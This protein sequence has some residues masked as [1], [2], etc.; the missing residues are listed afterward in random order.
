LRIRAP[1]FEHS[2]LQ[3][4]ERS[5]EISKNNDPHSSQDERNELAAH[6][7]VAAAERV[8]GLELAM[9]EGQADSGGS[10]SSGSLGLM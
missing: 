5:L 7:P 3:S 10:R 2:S 6:A 4:L 1:Q 8:N 9:S